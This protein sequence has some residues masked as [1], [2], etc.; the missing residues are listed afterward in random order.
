MPRLN[1]QETAKYT[2]IAHRS[3]N[4]PF[5]DKTRALLPT[6]E[7]KKPKRLGTWSSEKEPEREHIE[8]WN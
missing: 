2:E 6:T 1:P 3:M 4:S 7:P 5:L 8:D